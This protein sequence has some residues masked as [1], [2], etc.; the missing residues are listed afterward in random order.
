MTRARDTEPIGLHSTKVKFDGHLDAPQSRI[1]RLAGCH[2]SWQV[3]DRG[4]PIAIR[5]LVDTYEVSQPLHERSPLR[6]AWRLTE[7]SVPFGISSPRWPLTVT[8]PGFVGCL[9]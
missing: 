7:A 3:R 6:P 2:A 8:R 1:D 4:A 5:V 9:N